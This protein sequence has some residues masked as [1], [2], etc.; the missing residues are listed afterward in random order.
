MTLVVIGASAPNAGRVT[1][2]ASARG[3]RVVIGTG[4]RPSW[5]IV[6]TASQRRDALASFGL[7]AFRVIEW[8]GL[9]G[10]T[11]IAP[12]VLTR[13]VARMAELGPYRPVASPAG[14]ALTRWAMPWIMRTLD[15]VIG[16]DGDPVE[17]LSAGEAAAREARILTK[18]A[19]LENSEEA[20]RRLAER[21]ARRAAQRA[22]E[23]A[24]RR[25]AEQAGAEGRRS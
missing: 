16:P 11:E 6:A 18:V 13:G 19:K 8:P 17:E 10:E 2:A 12:D 20:R 21:R 23:K 9:D 24:A 1:D 22:E 4:T 15:R 5:V 7:P 3:L 25:L 14:V